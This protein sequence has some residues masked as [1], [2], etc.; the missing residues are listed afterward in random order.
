MKRIDIQE[1]IKLSESGIVL[2]KGDTVYVV[3][4]TV[5]VSKPFGGNEELEVYDSVPRGWKLWAG[6]EKEGFVGIGFAG[7]NSNPYQL[8]KV[9]VLAQKFPSD[10]L[11]TLQR[12][13]TLCGF[14]RPEQY[15]RLKG[16]KKFSLPRY[17]NLLDSAYE[18]M[19]DKI[20]WQR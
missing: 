14:R 10:E 4:K 3:E 19:T 11:K 20:K 7:D 13:M 9:G 2:E 1:D 15:E 18:L 12:A 6:F 8:T 16:L 5:T 17:Q